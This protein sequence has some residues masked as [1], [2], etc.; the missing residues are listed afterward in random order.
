[1]GT[2]VAASEEKQSGSLSQ[3]PVGWR[4]LKLAQR[5]TTSPMRGLGE[6]GGGPG[7]DDQEGAWGRK[8]PE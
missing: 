7:G 8:S 5:T 6:R 3:Q 1:M 2:E 4:G